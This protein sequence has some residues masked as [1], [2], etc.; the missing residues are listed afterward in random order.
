MRN[1][2]NK[3]CPKQQLVWLLKEKGT[4]NPETREFLDIWTRE[5]EKQA[6]GDF[7]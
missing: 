2:N 6:E 7:T 4:D 1:R 5:Q 3:G